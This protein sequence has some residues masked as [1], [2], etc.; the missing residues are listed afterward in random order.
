MPGLGPGPAPSP[1]R[2]LFVAW[3]DLMVPDYSPFKQLFPFR[4]SLRQN[5]CLGNAAAVGENL[6]T[7]SR[8]C[9]YL[10][11]L[12]TPDKNLQHFHF[13]VSLSNSH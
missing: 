7:T 2:G 11:K 8:L 5:A 3:P 9:I 1:G 13:P 6:E 10:T 12:P 4:I